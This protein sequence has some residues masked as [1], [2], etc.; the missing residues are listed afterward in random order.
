MRSFFFAVLF[1]CSTQLFG[2]TGNYFLSHYAPEDDRLDNVCFDMA[3][4]GHGI[5]Y[6]ATKG[7]I[8]QF[9]GRLWNLISGDGAVYTLHTESS[10]Q[11]FWGGANG[12]GKI[13]EDQ[14]GVKKTIRLSDKAVTDV[15]QSVVTKDN[16]YFINDTSIFVYS[17]LS[18]RTSLISSSSLTGSFTGIFE[19]FDNVY[20]NTDRAGIFKISDGHLTK[21]KLNGLEN[22]EIIFASRNENTYL[23]GTADNRIFLCSNKLKI[24]EIVLSSQDYVRASVVVSGRWINNTLAAIGTLRGGVIFINPATGETQEIVNYNTG[25]P[26]NEVFCMMNDQN[27]NLWIAHDY[28]FTRIAPY[29]PLHSFSHYEGLQGNLLCARTFH[30]QV[31]VGTSLGL[32][33]LQKVELYDEIIYYVNVPVKEIKKVPKKTKGGKNTKVQKVKEP[34]TIAPVVETPIITPP[35][36]ES[37]KKGFFHFLRKNKNKKETPTT[38][39]A[40]P[41][42]VV[43]ESVAEEKPSVTIASKQPKQRF[44]REKRIQRILRS[45]QFVYKRVQG[46]DAKVSQILEVNEKLLSVGLSGVHEVNGLQASPVLEEPVRFAFANKKFLLAST[47]DDEIRSWSLVNNKWERVTL[48]DNLDDQ[49]NYIFDGSGDDLW[50]CSTNKVYHTK[51]ADANAK[52]IEAIALPGKNINAS[53]GLTIRGQ[54]WIVNSNGFFLCKNNN[55]IKVD[56]LGIPKTY[57]AGE[58]AVW[59]RDQ[60]HWTSFGE[61]ATQK[62]LQLLNIFSDLRFITADEDKKK[63][64]LITANNELYKFS[65]EREYQKPINY[66]LFVKSIR[67]GN[68]NIS[69]K[70]KIQIDERE[71]SLTVEV[72]KPDYVGAQSIEYRYWL[73]G[74]HKEWSEWS[75][76]NNIVDFPYLPTGTYTLMVQSKDVFGVLNEMRPLLLQVKPPYWQRTW[77]YALEFGIFASLVLLS[78]RLSSKYLLVSRILSLLTIILLIQFIQTA[79]AAT[80]SSKT[81]VIDFIIQVFIA[82]LILPVEG[83]LRKLMLKSSEG[84]GIR[85]LIKKNK[86]ERRKK[87]KAAS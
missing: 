77:F 87:D 17:K 60:H 84:T 20:V 36:A 41:D 6:F 19:L 4:D 8:L 47:Y 3:Q 54:A 30:H 65:E 59:Y 42:P 64:W 62:N 76:N 73:R 35:V 51:I 37:K 2:Q 12:Y 39:T 49:I 46:V 79:A 10:G 82:L 28:G 57:F 72:V 14:N 61:Q 25:L 27:Q 48:F 50:L 5:L 78:F 33:T 75:G 80:F 34:E 22:T 18:N 1:L 31:Y 11:I 85:Q 32:F 81:P 26:D 66:P 29:V 40:I 44:K 55:F 23:I 53:V 67:N 69:D 68:R 15:F 58:N 24:K 86:E 71:S 7:G 43:K 74:L 56:T 16:A 52:N 70:L 83:Y 21:A 9:D 63:L 13:S 45:A 38:E